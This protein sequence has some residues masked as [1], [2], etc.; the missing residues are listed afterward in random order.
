MP[1]CHPGNGRADRSPVGSATWASDTEHNMG[2]IDGVNI[3][4]IKALEQRTAELRAAQARF[5]EKTRRLDALDRRVA[6]LDSM[7]RKKLR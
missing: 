4:A 5:D 6:E 2:D 3:A 7:V 1:V